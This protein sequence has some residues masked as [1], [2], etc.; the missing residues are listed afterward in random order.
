[1]NIFFLL[2]VPFSI[3]NYVREI[4]QLSLPIDH[5]VAPIPKNPDSKAKFAKNNFFCAA[6]LHPL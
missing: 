3:F 4:L 2:F 1:M 6:I 5:P